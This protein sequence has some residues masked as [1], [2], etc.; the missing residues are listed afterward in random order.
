MSEDLER[1]T[2]PWFT[3]GFDWEGVAAA[4]RLLHGGLE[5]LLPREAC[6]LLGPKSALPGLDIGNPD[7]VDV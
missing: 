1:K 7:A 4:L 3:G 6:R 2:T 5:R